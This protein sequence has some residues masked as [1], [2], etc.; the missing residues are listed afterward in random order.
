MSL[1]LSLKPLFETQEKIEQL[2]REFAERFSFRYNDSLNSLV[3]KLGGNIVCRQSRLCLV[4]YDHD[5]FD[6]IP[7]T[8]TSLFADKMFIAQAIG[9]YWLYYGT[10]NDNGCFACKRM[11]NLDNGDEK[12]AYTETTWFG[13]ELLLPRK[14]FT[15]IYQQHGAEKAVS[16]FQFPLNDILNRA[17]MLNIM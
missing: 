2:A 8:L 6:I 15:E 17:K 3:Q 1:H 14:E 9:Y 16:V 13:H 11:P 12:R 5:E 4:V 10:Q 7:P